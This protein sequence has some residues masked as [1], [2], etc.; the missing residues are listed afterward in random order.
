VEV[1]LR[2]LLATLGLG[3]IAIGLA[4]GWDSLLVYLFLVSIPAALTL[5]LVVGGDWLTQASRGRFHQGRRS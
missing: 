3:A 4:W 2:V 5:G 1:A